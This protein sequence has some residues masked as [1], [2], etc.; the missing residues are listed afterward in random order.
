[1][2]VVGIVGGVGAGKTMV[3]AAF[4]ALGCARIDADALGHEVLGDPAVQAFVRNRWGPPCLR[5]DGD[6]DRAAVGRI[7][8]ADPAELAALNE[9]THPRIR[10][11]IVERIASA[12]RAGAPAAVLD[13]AVLF[14]AGWDD[15]C[16]HTVF[17]AAPPAERRRRAAARSGWDAAAWAAREKTQIS[18]D[19]KA[20]S[21]DYMIENCTT[22]SDLQE[23]VCSLFD[24]IVRGAGPCR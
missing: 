21:C 9:V 8:F 24:Q 3:A 23:R 17:V 22:V 15:L 6:V 10:R 1:M 5:A 11:R 20:A 18:L 4:E 2:L 16:T 14:E 12:R 7:V 13:A 19:K